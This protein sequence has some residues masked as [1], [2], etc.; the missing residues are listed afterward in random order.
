MASPFIASTP[1]IKVSPVFLLLFLFL[2]TACSKDDDEISE[3]KDE[4]YKGAVTSAGK[5]QLIGNWAIFEV[6]YNGKTADVP[7]TYEECGRDFF[8]F[9]A[10]NTYR[11]FYFTSSYQCEK[12]V[13]DL[14]YELEDGIISLR[15]EWGSSEEM[16]IT[17]LN[18]D[19]LVFKMKYDVD[20]DGEPDV[21]SFRARRYTPPNDI[22]LY[23]YTFGPEIS[24]ANRNEIK[25]TW[26]GYDGFYKFDRYEIYRSN[27]GCGKG[28]AQLVASITEPSQNYFIDPNPPVAEAICYYL[29]IYNEKGLL[30]ESELTEFF[31]EELRP[32]QVDFINVAAQN[33]EVKLEWQPFSGNYFSHYEITVR[34]YKDGSGYGYL[35]YPVATIKDRE[36]STFLDKNPPRLKD[37]VYAIYVYDIFGNVSMHHYTNKNAWELSWTHPEVLNFDLIQFLTPAPNSS[38]VFFYGRQPGGEYQL[39]K[40]NYAN[41][42][43]SATAEK[44]P[45]Y[46]TSIPMQVHT[47]EYG[48]ELY[49][50]QGNSLWIYDA[51]D[52]S[53]KYQLNAPSFF[54]FTYLGNNIFS[55][56]DAN[57]ISTY[58]RTNADLELISKKSHFS[59]H[60]GDAGYHLLPLKNGEVLVGHYQE[61]KSYK[62]TVDAKGALS[63]GQLVD[64]PIRSRYQKKTLYSP[65]K[66]YIINLL[67]NKIYSTL[68]YTFREYVEQPAFPLGISEDGNLIFGTRNDPQES[69]SSTSGHEKAARIYNYSTKTVKAVETKGY[70]HFLFENHLGQLIS[71][72]SG[73]K[74][75]KLENSAPKPDVFVEVL[76]Y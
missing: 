43:V 75:D 71:I 46:Y 33:N 61:P 7:A 41:N 74:R 12:I 66:D 72:S 25:Y 62:F 57:T 38:E 53:F 64:I 42:S 49:Y 13:Q 15:D 36:T 47:G 56:T 1:G 6:A 23:S 32:T 35:E 50:A 5:Q 70:P 52:L 58:R 26:Q 8:Q 31:T 17:L 44:K 9:T 22:D 4:F 2:V 60:T 29:K 14:S 37:P 76:N 27:A 34:N 45:Q 55:F 11:D 51:E 65:N 68:T 19:R 10:T 39:V 73:F 40:Y 16:V 67:D 69:V 59:T 20:E 63:E 18:S 3:T 54:N 28:N 21:L 30:G 24:D 48:K